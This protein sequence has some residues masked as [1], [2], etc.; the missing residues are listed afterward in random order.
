MSEGYI[1]DE[2]TKSF[3]T[4]QDMEKKIKA[5]REAEEKKKKLADLDALIQLLVQNYEIKVDLVSGVVSITKKKAT[6]K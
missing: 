6:Q 5:K 2:E 4:I 3:I 1:W